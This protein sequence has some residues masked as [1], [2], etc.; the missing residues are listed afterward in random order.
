MALKVCNTLSAKLEAF[1]PLESKVRMFVCGPT[2][3]DYSHIGHARTYIAFDVIAKYLRYLGYQLYYVQNI[4]DIDDKII[5]RSNQEGITAS[6]LAQRFEDEYYKDIAAIGVNSVDLYARA[7]QHIPQIVRQIATLLDKGFAYV[8]TDG[9]IYYDVEKFRDYGK[10]SHRS[11]NDVRRSERIEPDPQKKNHFD[12]SL[13]KRQKPGEPT[14][15]S[16]WGLGRPG[17]H[18]EDTAITEHYLGPQYDIHG[19][20]QDLIFPHHEAEIA[21]MEAASGKVP[22]VKYWLHTGFLMVEAEVE[23]QKK[24]QKM[25][26]SLGNFITIRDALQRYDPKV[27]RLL[28][29]SVHYRSPINFSYELGDEIRTK[30]GRLQ[31]FVDELAR[32]SGGEVHGDPAA[33]TEVQQLIRS[34]E[35]VFKEAMDNDFNTPRA[36]AVIYDLVN[37]G[38]KLI[39]EGK[40]K[41]REAQDI[42]S[43]LGSFNDIFGITNIQ[44]SR[45]EDSELERKVLEMVAARERAREDKQWER[46][47]R[48]RED[49][50]RMGVEIRDSTDGTVWRKLS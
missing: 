8:T 43:M 34:S 25:S 45:L 46:A 4:T 30:A 15:D 21:Q 20:A 47:D 49:L 48:I 2:V 5:D 31:N 37:K 38:F 19:G 35:Q 40:V 12:F 6:E 27:L 41:A 9:N 26:K 14:W 13:W 17:W 33:T 1:A 7:A 24:P 23:G 10:L 44:G 3:Y 22:L 29:I 39:S 42:L 18:I 28:M 11:L 32:I 36:V 50:T 16:P